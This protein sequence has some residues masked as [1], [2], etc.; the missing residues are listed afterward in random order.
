MG[1]AGGR[2]TLYK[3]EY[4]DLAFKYCLLGATNDRLAELFDVAPSTIDLWIAQHD[5]FSGSVKAGRF[6]A[7]AEVA[8]A[9]YHRAKGYSHPAVKIFADAKSGE[10]KIIPYTEHYPPDTAA[11]FIWLKNRAGWKDKHDHEMTGKDGKD[12]IPDLSKEEIAR[13]IAFA[14]AQ[15]LKAKQEKEP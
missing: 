13:N 5:G 8:S 14:L 12:L 11:A 6:K 7:D 15:G 9:L 2:P 1:D 4:D 3:P 10:E